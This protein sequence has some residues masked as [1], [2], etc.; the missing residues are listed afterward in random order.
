MTLNEI[1]GAARAD[2]RSAKTRG[3]VA[4]GARPMVGPD[5]AVAIAGF[6]RCAHARAL[7]SGDLRSESPVLGEWKGRERGREIK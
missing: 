7:T 4:V 3:S 2:A 6:S 1:G 5:L